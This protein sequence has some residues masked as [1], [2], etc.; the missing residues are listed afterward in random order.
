MKTVHVTNAV[1]LVLGQDLTKIVP[2]E[3]KGVAFHKGHII[4]QEDIPVMLSMG[5]DHVYILEMG[6]RDVHE[7]AAAEQ[8]SRLAAGANI[9]RQ[10]ASEGK[11]TMIADTFGLLDIHIDKLLQINEMTG[12]AL[13]TLH[14][15]TL[16]KK[17]DIVA[18]AKII[19]LTLPQDTLD[20]IEKICALEKII[21]IRPMPAK[22][23]GLVVTGN[24]VFYGRIKDRFKEVIQKK[25]LELGS[26]L[27]Q[28]IF[29]P[30][31]ANKVSAAIKELTVE[32]DLVFVTG[33]MSVDPDDITPLAV[34]QTGADVI[35]YG[36]PVLPGAMF[37]FAYLNGTPILGIP[38]CG[39]FS[40]ITVLDVILPKVLVGEKITSRIIASLGHGGLCRTCT[41]G[42]HYPNCSFCK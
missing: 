10:H 35:V 15:G 17:D 36:T 1:G 20:H 29:V 12:V 38:A 40:K 8:L 31:D 23:A 32:N 13:S 37:L 39:M 4:C 22:K 24:E 18:A 14:T 26:D 6:P 21:S 25:V 5:K 19:P 27:S 16:V 28:T 33:G 34:R 3:F 11:V 2:G 41:E 9:V 42:C 7:N 30:D